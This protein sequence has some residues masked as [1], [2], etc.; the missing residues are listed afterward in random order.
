MQRSFISDSKY[1]FIEMNL[2]SKKTI[3]AQF[4]SPPTVTSQLTVHFAHGD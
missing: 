2:A 1:I 4:V 3:T